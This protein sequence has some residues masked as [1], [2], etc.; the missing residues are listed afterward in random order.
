MKV[1]ELNESSTVIKARVPAARALELQRKNATMST[2]LLACARTIYEESDDF[3]DV[4]DFAAVLAAMV[5]T[6]LRE[7]GYE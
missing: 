5:E 7:G 1:C 2:R 4:S 6:Y 3:A